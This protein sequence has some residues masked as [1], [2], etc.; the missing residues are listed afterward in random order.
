MMNLKSL[1]NLSLKG[2]AIGAALLLA[3]QIQA[4]NTLR[5][6][7]AGDALTM[8]PHA[9]NETPTI[10][11]NRQVYDTLIQRDQN[12]KMEPGLALSWE[13]LSATSWQFNLRSGVTFH[14]GLCL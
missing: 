10:N 11:M 3:T 4:A 12:L 14:D 1:A 6:S 2:A 5:W 7:S 9:K 13:P 8:D